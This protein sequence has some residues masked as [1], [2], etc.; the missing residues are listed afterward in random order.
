MPLTIAELKNLVGDT[1]AKELQDK[2]LSIYRFAWD[3]AMG[4][5]VIIADTKLEFGFVEGEIGLVDEL[6][7]PDSSRFWDAA[8]FEVG[9]PQPSFDKE[10]VRDWL[11][12]YGWNKEP[13]APPLPPHI[14]E[15]TSRRYREAYRR[16]TGESL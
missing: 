8:S 2:S 16:L 15:E 14:I 5:G 4:R 12:E 13:P 9:H 10:P 11:V 1:V 7:T 3:Y 6:L